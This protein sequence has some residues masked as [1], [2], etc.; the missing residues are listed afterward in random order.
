VVWSRGGNRYDL[1]GR[2]AG[3]G[4]IEHIAVLDIDQPGADGLACEHWNSATAKATSSNLIYTGLMP[5]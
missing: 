2:V 1:R 4:G 3:G 5:A